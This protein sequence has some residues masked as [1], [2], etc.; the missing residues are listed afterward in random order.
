M[1]RYDRWVSHCLRLPDLR[2]V[3]ATEMLASG[4]PIAIVSQ[5][6]SHARAST[7]QNVYAHSV[8]AATAGPGKPSQQS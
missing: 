8:P 3:M 5:R 6:L 2:Q 4:V 1:W 7:T